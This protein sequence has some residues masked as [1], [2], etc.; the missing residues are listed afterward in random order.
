[1][2]TNNLTNVVI[3]GAAGRDFHDFNVYWKNR[4][5][6]RVVAFTAA[7]IPDIADRIYPAS[8]CGERYPEGIPI[9]A[10]AQLEA[11]IRDHHVQLVA[12]A[13]SDV[14]YGHVMQQAARAA[15]AGARFE[16]LTP[17]LTML[18]SS[19]PV[20]AVCAIRTGCGKSQTTRR[21]SQLLRERGKKI[22]VLRHPMPYGDLTKQICQ[23]FAT[24]SDLDKHDCTIE[25]RE[26]YEPHIEAGNLLFA[27]IDYAAILRA[28]EQEADVILWDGGNN[29][30]PFLKP[31]LNICVTDPHRAGH[32]TSYYPG[33][34]NLRMADLVVVNK[35][36]TA[37]PAA[38]ETLV[39]N[40]RR[41]NSGAVVLKARSPVS[42]SDPAAIRG[43]RVLVIEDGPTLTHGEMR[44]GAGHVAAKKFGAAQIVDPRP[45]AVGS[46]K[47]TFARYTHLSE[48]LPAMGY[49]K[50]QMQ[51]LAA[52]IR[53]VPC[54]LV[55]IGTPIDLAKLIDVPQPTM[56]VT[57]ELDVEDKNVLPSALARVV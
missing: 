29:D 7:Q 35:V 24:L 36:D 27:G 45:Y 10:E 41:V 38:V 54:D 39:K 32:E 48:I 50:R 37:D 46:I 21:V 11:I 47:D 15:A 57:Y 33:E 12:F 43:K 25:E 53:Q 23:R 55:L 44:I 30:T 5:D 14:P 4:T 49:G 52:T 26:E 17:H 31:N 20:V 51:E 56:R 18:K 40:I 6:L 3:M 19:K 8:L 9:Y 1:M 34:V 22:A 42:V 2:S 28:A 16:L 13:Y